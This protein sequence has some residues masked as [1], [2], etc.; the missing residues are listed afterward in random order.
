MSVIYLLNLISVSI[1]GIILSAAFC[2]IIWTRKKYLIFAIG[3]AV[4]FVLQAIVYFEIDLATVHSL[5]PLITHLPLFLTLCVLSKK[6]LWPL[7]SVLSAYLCC[8][9]RRWLALLIVAVSSGGSMTQNIAE[10]LLT[11]PLLVFLVYFAAPSVRSLS[12]YTVSVQCQFGL[13]PALY[14][15]FDYLT[16]IYTDW[17]EQGTL[18]AVEFMPFVCSV[19]YLIFVLRISEEERVRLRLEQTQ[20]ILNL[21]IAQSVREIKA[22]RESQHQASI[23]RHDLRHH[24]QYLSTCLENGRLEQAQTYIQKICSEIETQTLIVFCENEAANLVFSAFTGRAREYGIAL[25][26]KAKIPP[27]IPVSEND[28]CVLLSNALENALHAC[29]KLKEKGL[30]GTIEVSAY[31]KNGSF[32][33]QIINSCD[34]DITFS[35][36]IPISKNPGHGIGVRSICAIV[37]HYGG[38]YTFKTKDGQ[39]ILQMIL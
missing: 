38:I 32:F 17:L 10:L 30:P 37:E 21:Q 13:I 4:N 19:A 33:F 16:R 34:S 28:L 7:I 31:E 6:R 5:Y 35:H 26:I 20:E 22:M 15:A 29:Q 27:N 1:F 8:Q 11:L 23:Y 25:D 3:T 2:D 39:F 14:Y 18:V 12:H 36:G 9:I 24:A